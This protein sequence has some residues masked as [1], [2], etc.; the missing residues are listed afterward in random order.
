MRVLF[1]T[2]VLLDVLLDREPWSEDS[3]AVLTMAERSEIDGTACAISFT[4]IF[5]L[6]RKEFGAATARGEVARLLALL[7]VAPVGFSTLQ[8]AVEAEVPRLRG[9]RR[10]RVCPHRE[11]DYIVTRDL[12]DFGASPIPVHTPESFR[13]LLDLMH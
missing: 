8:R 11:R 6:L 4:T 9:C 10:G 7:Q 13:K 12:R 2:N 3:S 5:Y 1:D